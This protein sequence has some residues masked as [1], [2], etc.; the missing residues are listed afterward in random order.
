MKV[1]VN[2][3]DTKEDLAMKSSQ[4]FHLL[5]GM[6]KVLSK[7]QLRRQNRVTGHTDVCTH[8]HTYTV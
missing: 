3:L 2:L 8:I 4:P 7:V 5:W 1:L 6:F